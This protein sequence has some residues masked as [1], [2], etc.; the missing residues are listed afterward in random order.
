MNNVVFGKTMK[1]LR[2]QGHILLITKE[3]RR[4]YLVSQYK[5]FTKKLLATEIKTNEIVK[6]KSV[7]L[8]FSILELSMSMS[9]GMIM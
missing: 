1:N 5:F 2:K 9:F 4:N 8:G 6:N 7:Q 3:R